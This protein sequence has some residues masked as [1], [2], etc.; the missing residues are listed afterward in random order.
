M[1]FLNEEK[2]DPGMILSNNKIEVVFDPESGGI[3]QILNKKVSTTY[4]KHSSDRLVYVWLLQKGKKSSVYANDDE[5]FRI[6]SSGTETIRGIRLN[7]DG[8]RSSI[9][10]LHRIESVDVKCR[11]T[12]E[13]ESPLLTCEVEID[14]TLN[15]SC[16]ED[17]VS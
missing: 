8:S 7:K 12:L 11:F 1:S 15:P 16:S 4:L 2:V 10:V 9:E 14:N 5:P 17:V 13:D 3:R 6:V